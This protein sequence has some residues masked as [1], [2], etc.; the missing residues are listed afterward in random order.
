MDG[1]PRSDVIWSEF[2][3]RIKA[4]D[5]RPP[6]HVDFH[7]IDG[8]DYYMLFFH[9]N[10]V[11][12]A[13]AMKRIG[14][15]ARYIQHMSYELTESDFAGV[16]T[17]GEAVPS[18]GAY[19]VTVNAF[20]PDCACTPDFEIRGWYAG[21]RGLVRYGDSR[22]DVSARLADIEVEA[23]SGT[24]VARL[25]GRTEARTIDALVS[26]GTSAVVETLDEP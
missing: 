6:D 16:V 17:A 23:D 10:D 18:E 4:P 3:V 7:V 19:R 21:A 1:T 24:L 5:D 9:T 15:P 11:V 2:G 25:M 13:N 22:T 14:T 20:T 26:F 12:L 8:H